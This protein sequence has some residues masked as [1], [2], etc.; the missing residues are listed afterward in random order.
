MK[1]F[2]LHLAADLVALHLMVEQPILGHVHGRMCYPLVPLAAARSCR[3]HPPQRFDP[4]LSS[5]LHDRDVDP[6]DVLP[7]DMPRAD[8]QVPV[9]S[10]TNHTIKET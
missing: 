2:A 6:D 8:V 3:A 7:H 4:W 1:I 10:R 9:C 5:M